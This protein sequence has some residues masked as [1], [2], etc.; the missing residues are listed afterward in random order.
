MISFLLIFTSSLNRNSPAKTTRHIV[1]SLR[2]RSEAFLPPNS[3]TNFWRFHGLIGSFYANCVQCT[4]R[5]T[6]K[7]WLPFEHFLPFVARFG[8][9]YQQ[10]ATMSNA[11]LKWKHPQ[12]TKTSRKSHN[13]QQK[14]FAC[15][16][17]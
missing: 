11:M 17:F 10:K 12:K 8:F 6:T 5:C 15:F 13:K 3:F 2:S 14:T 9:M 4:F 7:A 16:G 1:R